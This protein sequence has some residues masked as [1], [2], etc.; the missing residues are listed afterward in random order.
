MGG[1]QIKNQNEI[2]FITC[3]IVGWIDVFS[4]KKYKDVIVESFNYCIE[5]KGLMIY[6][7]VIMSNHIH[8]IGQAKDGFKLS[9]I[10]RDF[11]KF[12]ATKIIELIRYSK[13]ESRSEWILRLFKYYAK[14]NSNNK[15]YQFW[16]RSNRPIELHSEKWLFQKLDYIHLNP[17]KAALVANAY[18]YI[19]SSASDYYGKPGLVKINLIE[20]AMV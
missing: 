3:T 20:D 6:A 18:E 14:F 16:Q 11:K 19:Y 17:V 4:R 8:F 5:E 1:H 9:D 2:H 10:L 15:V 7:Y 13:K 12:T